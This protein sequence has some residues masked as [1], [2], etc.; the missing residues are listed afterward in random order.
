MSGPQHVHE[1]STET[2]VTYPPTLGIPSSATVKVATP[3]TDMPDSG[4]AAT[5][6]SVSSTT[7]AAASAGATSLSF[8]GDPST[9]VGRQYLLDDTSNGKPLIVVTVRE[10]GTTLYLEEPLPFDVGSGATLSGIAIT[11]ALTASETDNA[12][13]GNAEWTATVG[14][15]ALTWNQQFR[16][17]EERVAYTLNND[18]L[19]QSYPQ[20][21][22]LAG[23]SD[24]GF[25]ELIETAWDH[26]LR[27]DL[28]ARGM[29][30]E[31]INSWDALEPAH[32]AACYYH[33]LATNPRT[34]PDVADRA[35]DEYLST[36]RTTLD[37]RGFWYD[38]EDDDAPRADDDQPTYQLMVTR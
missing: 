27:L 30:P 2:L 24:E 15:V 8:A 20:I 34:D 38:E 14:G 25:N 18:R 7:N 13:E 33:A 29:R 36:L 16:I 37:A 32:A 23:R 4:D 12:G 17:V 5:V 31:R 35:K 9:T 26:R 3:S 6:D 19:T 28:A 1:D 22:H 11:H 21:R 10:N